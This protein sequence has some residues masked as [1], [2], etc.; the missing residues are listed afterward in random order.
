M[1]TFGDITA[2]LVT[3]GDVD[4]TPIVA[5]LD[6]YAEVRI[7]DNSQI[8]DLGAAGRVAAM[9]LS[10]TEYVYTQDDD[11]IFRD[12]DALLDSFNQTPDLAICNWAHGSFTGGFHDVGFTGAGAILPRRLAIHALATFAVMT[13][14]D[15][16]TLRRE[17]DF[18]IGIL[19]PHRHVVLPYE[20]LP[21]ATAPNRLCNTVGHLEARMRVTNLA[22]HLKWGPIIPVFAYEEDS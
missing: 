18:A 9:I 17:A 10:E 3:R 5:T 14:I 6:A 2:C 12:H 15:G 20:I 8:G 16:E 1:I 22:R 19:M 21:Q 11:V 7:W 4:M 13:E